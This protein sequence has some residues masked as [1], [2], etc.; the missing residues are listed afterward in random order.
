MQFQF[1]RRFDFLGASKAFIFSA[2]DFVLVSMGLVSPT[3]E[4]LESKL[5]LSIFIAKLKSLAVGF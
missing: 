2:C 3:K 5:P 1:P 4:T